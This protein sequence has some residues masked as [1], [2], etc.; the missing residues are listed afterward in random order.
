MLNL[1]WNSTLNRIGAGAVWFFIATSLSG[2]FS[3]ISALGIVP[4]SKGTTTLFDGAMFVIAS[5][6]L[7]SVLVAV[8]RGRITWLEEF[9]LAS[10]TENTF[11]QTVLLSYVDRSDALA[12]LGACLLTFLPMLLLYFLKEDYYVASWLLFAVIIGMVLLYV[13]KIEHANAKRLLSLHNALSLRT[14]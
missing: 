10:Q 12:G 5:Y 11:L 7:G 4:S 13:A 8:G 6:F 3:F 14:P 1:V 2:G 9:A